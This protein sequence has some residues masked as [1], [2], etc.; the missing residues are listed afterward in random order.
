[1]I[2]QIKYNRLKKTVGDLFN[3]SYRVRIFSSESREYIKTTNAE[4]F[5][6]IYASRQT[7]EINT[8]LLRDKYNI[9][10]DDAV[11]NLFLYY[12]NEPELNKYEVTSSDNETIR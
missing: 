6:S 9:F 2:T 1:M 5:I 12:L 8:A 10:Y 4:I 11:H 3:N 7:L